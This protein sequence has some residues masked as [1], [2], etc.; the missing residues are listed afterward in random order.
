MNI[1]FIGSSGH[2][3]AVLESEKLADKSD[4]SNVVTGIA[5]GSDGENIENLYNALC[6]LNHSP[7]RYESY[8]KMMDDLKPDIV[9]I[10]NYFGEHAKVSVEA[11]KR[12]CHVLS[13]KPLATTV[14]SL[15][16]LKKEQAKS[17]KKIA[18]MFTMRFDP[19]FT[20]AYEVVKS[21]EIGDIRLINAQKSYKL[22]TR[23]DFYK[24]RESFGGL[25]PWVG[26]HAID[27]IYFISG[28]KFVYIDAVSSSAG[29]C[30]YGD[31]D[32]TA[33]GSFISENNIISTMT[34]DYLRP[35]AALSHG[36]NKLRIVGS[37]G[38]LEVMENKVKL[39]NGNGE[40]EIALL[41]KADIFADFLEYIDGK[42]NTSLNSD[43]AFYITETALEAQISADKKKLGKHS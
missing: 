10:D 8:L 38:I 22:G 6:R 2:S 40:I 21:G 25:I 35:S 19:E 7:K 42:E 5:A 43:D 33:A 12:G 1:C 34:I 29:N 15:N 37:S 13:D 17:G 11:L 4:K 41:D 3:Y 36:D 24:S 28:K 31:L 16:E 23:P 9:V 30:G 39:I 27:L 26:I 18:A 32:I 14:D 20:T